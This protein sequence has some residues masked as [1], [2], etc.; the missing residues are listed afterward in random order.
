MKFTDTRNKE[1]EENH[2]VEQT[3]VNEAEEVSGA[4][5]APADEESVVEIA[6]DTDETIKMETA[7]EVPVLEGETG[8]EVK[9]GDEEKGESP[10]AL[11]QSQAPSRSSDINRRDASEEPRRF[12][13]WVALLVFSSVTLASVV[14]MRKLGYTPDDAEYLKNLKWAT[15]CAVCTLAFTSLMVLMQLHPKTT[16]IVVGT[17]V[18]GVLCIILLAFCATTVAIVTDTSNGLAVSVWRCSVWKLVLL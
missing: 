16:L 9:V 6:A 4:V 8:V 7:V 17:K 18:E 10:A 14:R 2:K 1:K 5:A 3:K 11:A 12:L 15:I 13:H